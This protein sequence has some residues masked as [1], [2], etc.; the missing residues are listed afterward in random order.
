MSHSPYVVYP[1][2]CWLHIL[3]AGSFFDKFRG[4]H[5]MGTAL[6]IEYAPYLN[7]SSYI[8]QRHESVLVQW[9][10]PYISRYLLSLMM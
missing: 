7:F 5:L 8:N 4:Y 6:D 9:I 1:T 2:S 10:V 3:V